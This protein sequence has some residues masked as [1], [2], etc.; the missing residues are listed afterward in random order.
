M[1]NELSAAEQDELV[2]H[3][4]ECEKCQQALER[5]TS[6]NE[7]WAAGL[8]GLKDGLAGA[9]P[10]LEQVLKDFKKPPQGPET[11]AE[12]AHKG[13]FDF[14]ADFLAPP[15]EPG[16]LG[17]LGHYEVLETIGRGG[18][19][20]VL[21]ALDESLHRVVAIK[22][23]SPHLASNATARKRFTREAQAAAAVTHEHVVTIHAVED[24]HEPPYIVMQFVS[25]VSLQ[26]RLDRDGPLELKEI[27]RIGMQTAQGLAAAHA[28]GVVHRDIKPANI[29]LENGV[30]RVKITDFGLARTLDDASLTQS[31]VVAGTPQY[32]SPEQA[33]GL[34]V[35]HRT[36]QFSL[37]S[38]LYAL[39]TGR[40]PFRASTLMGVLKRVSEDEPRPVREINPDIPD[41]LEAIIERLHAKN[42]ADRFQS[43]AEL[44]D[45]LGRHLAYLQ[46]P[47]SVPRPRTTDVRPKRPQAQRAQSLLWLGLALV[48]AFGCC[49]LPVGLGVYWFLLDS[50]KPPAPSSL[51]ATIIEV[52]DQAQEMRAV[53][54]L[55]AQNRHFPLPFLIV[56][57]KDQGERSFASLA[58]AVA[59]ARDG[60]VIEVR[61]SGVFAIAPLIIKDKALTIRATLGFEPRFVF[62]SDEKT[63]TPML[64]TNASLVL[65]GLGFK[66]DVRRQISITVGGL[67]ITTGAGAGLRLEQSNEIVRTDGAPLHAANCRFDVDFGY[68]C[69]RARNCPLL[70]LRNCQFRGAVI[71][72]VD[73]E[74]SRDG[75]AI[76]ENCILDTQAGIGF[77]CR[78]DLRDASIRLNSNTIVGSWPFVFVLDSLPDPAV[79][80][81]PI[82]VTATENA[83]HGTAGIFHFA[84]SDRFLAEER[85][86]SN[87]QALMEL[88]RVVRWTEERNV[89]EVGAS[90]M[91]LATIEHV[92]D[93]EQFWKADRTGSLQGTLRFKVGAPFG[94]SLPPE[95]FRLQSESIGQAAGRGGRDLGAD[96]TLV[97]PSQA[98]ERWRMTPDYKEW[99]NTTGQIR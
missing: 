81:P 92:K 44:A 61:A 32:M 88:A 11:Q 73:W 52:P 38:V 87:E 20:V 85:R 71:Y 35:D 25:G 36:D 41:W 65:E 40:P 10:A 74:S 99:L 90:Y 1:H 18:M 42:P 46:R 29:L 79:A 93:W 89:Y 6:E 91:N 3:L 47:G 67:E 54:G 22:V 58:E 77:H 19:G 26:D 49:L 7:S 30:E 8:R 80:K 14:L 53:D 39:C 28:Q 72:A 57:R 94:P 9:E 45:L 24:A 12:P 76:L 23:L 66:R 97:G 70:S 13:F 69:I 50:S 62:T 31:G 15:K 64:Q 83:I 51:S 2:L 78:R 43:A 16:H 96:V 95:S 48:L 27:L 75:H 86:L 17:R 55:L 4:N 82:K 84:Q 21:K 63:D 37:G 34:A 68:R 59:A 33:D 56:A 98:Y 60:D 5:L